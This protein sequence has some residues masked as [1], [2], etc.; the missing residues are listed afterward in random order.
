M[1]EQI[2]AEPEQY[3]IYVPISTHHTKFIKTMSP[4][5]AFWYWSL[6]RQSHNSSTPLVAVALALA[7]ALVP[8]AEPP[9]VSGPE[10]VLADCTFTL[11]KAF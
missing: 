4:T 7:L 6:K 1:S 9:V 5:K 2:F 10:Y 11:K 8:V 3:I